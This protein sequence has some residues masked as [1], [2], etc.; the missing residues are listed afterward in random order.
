MYHYF[1]V[2]KFIGTNSVLEGLLSEAC[3]ARIISV[4]SRSVKRKTAVLEIYRVLSIFQRYVFHD[5]YCLVFAH[6]YNSKRLA[7]TELLC[8]IC[9]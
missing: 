2:Q 1:S 8:F 6:L 9:C 3:I 4:F 5:I 7:K